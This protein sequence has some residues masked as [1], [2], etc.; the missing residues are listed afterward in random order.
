MPSAGEMAESES[1]PPS[2]SIE[3]AVLEVVEM[4]VAEAEVEEPEAVEVNAE[5]MRNR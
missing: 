4:E 2:D 3:E 5:E 1:V